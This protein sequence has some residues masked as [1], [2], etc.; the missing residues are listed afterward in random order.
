MSQQRAIE[1]LEQLILKG[2]SVLQTHR[3][4]PPN[5][6]G[7]TT[8]DSGA[9]TEWKTQSLT[10]LVSL[11]GE[12][13]VYVENYREEITEGYQSVV[14][15]GIGILKAAKEDIMA[16]DLDRV[17]EQ[18]PLLILEQ[19]FSRFHLVA[20]QLRSRYGGRPTLDVQDEYDVQDLI[21]ALLC[22]HFTDVRPE[23]YTPSYAGKASR[24]DFL[25]KRESIA[26]EIKMTRSGLG[27]KE[28]STQLIEDIERYKVHPD[29]Q[30]LLCFVYDPAGLIP[31]PRGIE[32]DLNRDT[33][34]FPVRVF[35]R[36]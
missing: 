19:I 14:S 28:L 30:A 16:G 10:C 11:L 2:E 3:P 8:L 36:P 18:S 34:P 17:P 7:F 25:L 22:L 27:P 29:C 20:R 12:G 33:D 13:H 21:H 35:I 23:E 6:I 1:R 32:A 26:I 5:W 31:N 24:M 15:A 9:F 4:N